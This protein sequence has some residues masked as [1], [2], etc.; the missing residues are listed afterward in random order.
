[1]TYV[2][3]AVAA[4]LI[5][6]LLG[7]RKVIIILAAGAGLVLS[8]WI[9]ILAYKATHRQPER[10]LELT[11]QLARA[12]WGVKEMPWYL[13]QIKN[14]GYKEVTIQDKFWG[15]QVYLGRN[16]R[17][18]HGTYFEVIDPDGKPMK[19][20]FYR[21]QHGEFNFWANDCG[22]T[23]C[24]F[25][26]HR[27]IFYRTLKSGDILTATPSVVAPLREQGRQL[28][29]VDA[30]IPPG[31]SKAEQE[32]YKKLWEMQGLGRYDPPQKPLYPGYRVLDDYPFRKIGRYRMKV[33]YEPIPVKYAEEQ[34]RTG[35]TWP[36]I[37]G[38]PEETRIFRYESNEVEFE[39]VP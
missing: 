10:P 33:I 26:D 14:V 13:L 27:H 17:S 21:G 35:R 28:G 16:D 2:G 39:V 19:G 11:L 34:I 12:Q 25:D 4:G 18:K 7:R 31:A 36:S 24:A 32:S 15:E 37:G 22:G 5:A 30:R 23:I 38:L 1:M 9:G 29:L 3:L 8:I 20:S 6:Y